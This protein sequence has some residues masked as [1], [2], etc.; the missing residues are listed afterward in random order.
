MSM[1]SCKISC[2]S[3]AQHET[4]AAKGLGIGLSLGMGG[5]GLDTVK[6][7]FIKGIIQLSQAQ[8]SSSRYKGVKNKDIEKKILKHLTKS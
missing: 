7:S 6:G 2:L 5:D 8:H 3:L 1:P 4:E